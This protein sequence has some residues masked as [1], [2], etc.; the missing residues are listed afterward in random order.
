VEDFQAIAERIGLTPE[1]FDP[2]AAVA[3]G[4]NFRAVQNAL[5]A[6]AL[7]QYFAAQANAPTN[8][9]PFTPLNS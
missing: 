8:R 4:G 7:Q 2:V 5:T 1:E 9:R 6:R 3:S